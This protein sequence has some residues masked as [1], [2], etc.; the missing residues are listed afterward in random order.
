MFK[1]VLFFGLAACAYSEPLLITSGHFDLFSIDVF[2]SF[3][4]R[5]ILRVGEQRSFY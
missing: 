5:R 2:W 1:L 3:A 4:G